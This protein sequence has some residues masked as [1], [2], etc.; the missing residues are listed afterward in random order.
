MP[1]SQ[2]DEKDLRKWAISHRAR[3]ELRASQVCELLVE[4]EKRRRDQRELEDQLTSLADD[5]LEM[6][7]LL[8][9]RKLQEEKVSA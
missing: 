6:V 9:T 1:L 7:E 3:G 8:K 2:E 4:V 5:N